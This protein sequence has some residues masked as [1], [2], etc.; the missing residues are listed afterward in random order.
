MCFVSICSILLQFLT[1]VKKQNTL[2]LCKPLQWVK[3]YEFGYLNYN[4]RTDWL[5]ALIETR[6]E[7]QWNFGHNCN[8]L[9]RTTL[10]IKHN[11]ISKYNVKS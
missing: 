4:M 2:C 11:S 7:K 1:K 8:R 9:L 10:I 6:K 3:R 5:D